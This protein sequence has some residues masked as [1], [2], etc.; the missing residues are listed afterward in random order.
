VALGAVLISLPKVL[1]IKLKEKHTEQYAIKATVNGV[2]FRMSVPLK[3]AE[4]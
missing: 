2:D 4:C 1:K 3:V